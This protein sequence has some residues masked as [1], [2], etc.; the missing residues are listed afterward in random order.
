MATPEVDAAAVEAVA[1]EKV[2]AAVT[3]VMSLD[4]LVGD[5]PEVTAAAARL[6]A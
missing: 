6:V 3:V 1:S 5:T 4:T 2:V